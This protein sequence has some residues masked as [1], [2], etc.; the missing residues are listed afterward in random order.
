MFSLASQSDCANILTMFH[1][2]S[3]YCESQFKGI[4]WLVKP[5]FVWDISSSLVDLED[6]LSAKIKDN[7]FCHKSLCVQWHGEK[8]Y[9]LFSENRYLCDI[10]KAARCCQV[11]RPP[12][13]ISIETTRGKR[14][15]NNILNVK[16]IT[17]F[18][19]MFRSCS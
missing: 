13:V 5:L 18:Y 17:E 16:T 6:V 19:R 1:I 11:T 9:E 10:S 7:A 4:Y 15:F 8:R 14:R 12:S 2:L 3:P